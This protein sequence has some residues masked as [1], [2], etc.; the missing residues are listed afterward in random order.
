MLRSACR[1]LQQGENGNSAKMAGCA[2]CL[3]NSRIR[4]ARTV[5][6][7][8]L[9][10]RQTGAGCG[11]VRGTET[12]TVVSKSGVANM[13]RIKQLGSFSKEKSQK[14]NSYV[15]IVTR[16]CVLIRTTC[17]SEHHWTTFGIC[18]PRGER[19]KPKVPDAHAFYPRI[20]SSKCASFIKAQA[21]V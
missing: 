18:S 10:L 4:N 19:T 5:S 9:R 21:R 13:A 2:T 3:R 17:L 12:V 16:P 14:A 11:K 6:L 20:W 15:T 8:R 1:S 7:A